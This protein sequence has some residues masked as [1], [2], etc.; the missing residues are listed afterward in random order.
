MKRG[1]QFTLI[2]LLVVIAIIAILMSLLLPSLNTAR[3]LAKRTK[4]AG[5][6]R[7][8]SNCIQSYSLD[9]GDYIPA[10]YDGG[11]LWFQT[12]PVDYSGVAQAYT[13]ANGVTGRSAISA[14]PDWITVCPTYK[15]LKQNGNYGVSENWFAHVA[16]GKAYHKYIQISAPSG[17][18]FAT[19]VYYEGSN[20]NAAEQFYT[21]RGWTNT[22]FRHN[23]TLNCL[24]ADGHVEVRTSPFPT[25]AT[26]VIWRGGN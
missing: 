20:V 7:S 15:A 21:G 17:T 22:H 11:W 4:C 9:N 19:E 14:R 26:D 10:S 23:A 6:L 18:L 24:M 8:V 12:F 5:N 13:T 1:I 16:L 25:S 2:E 3:E